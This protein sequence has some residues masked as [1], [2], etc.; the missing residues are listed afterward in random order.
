MSDF[1]LY[2]KLGFRHITDL[3]A[4]DHILF[5][6]A[7][8]AIYQ[9]KHLKSIL[10]LVTAFTVGHS[11]SLMLSV[12]NIVNIRTDIV[13]FLIP[14]TILFT[15]LF[16]IMQKEEE[17]IGKSMKTKYGLAIFFGLI[18]GL[19]FSNYLK[20]SFSMLMK[21]D[22]SIFQPL[23]AFNVGLELGQLIIV[24]FILGIT[25]IFLNGLKTKQREW[26]LFISGLCSG[27]SLILLM[28]TKF[29]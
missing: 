3:T 25:Y 5:L 13:E 21:E 17:L 20:Q 1:S 15:C 16:N 7:L 27:I 9:L 14:V 2:L 4:Y 6:V 28:E 18:H 10:I 22:F 12:F 23:L 26:N 19:G 29:W 11:L 8:C 24:L